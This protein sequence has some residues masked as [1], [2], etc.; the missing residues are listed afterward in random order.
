MPLKFQVETLEGLA[1]EIATLY[2]E[3]DGKF[4]LDVEGVVPKSKLDEFRNTNV[5]LMRKLELVKDI[6][7]AEYKRLKTEVDKLK[8]LTENKPDVDAVVNERVAQMREELGAQLTELTG[9]NTK[10]QSQLGSLLIDSAV[11]DAALKH[12]ALPVAFDDLLLRARSSFQVQDGVAVMVDTKGHVIYDKDGET[13]MSVDS[14]LK[15]LKKTAVH[16]F[17]MP[18]GGGGAGGKG[19]GGIDMSKLS[20]TQKIKAGLDAQSGA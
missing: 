5:E 15:G 8:K 20:P 10:L 11:K 16:L 3:V 17:V 1:P 12:G 13:P 18:T 14:W 19:P 6:D 4:F 9:T 7:P 2:S